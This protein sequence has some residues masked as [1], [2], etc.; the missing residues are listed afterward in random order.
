MIQSF[1]YIDLIKFRLCF[2]SITEA[3]RIWEWDLLSPLPSHRQNPAWLSL[4]CK[5]LKTCTQSVVVSVVARKEPVY[6]QLISC[7]L[8]LFQSRLILAKTEF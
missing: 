4:N 1:I 7:Y 6:L 2:K 3:T 8:A 5:S